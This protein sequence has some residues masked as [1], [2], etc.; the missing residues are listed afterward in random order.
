MPAEDLPA[1]GPE[2]LLH[3]VPPL[4]DPV[5]RPG[6][7]RNSL[8]QHQSRQLLLGRRHVEQL[9]REALEPASTGERVT[10]RGDPERDWQVV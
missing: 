7:E 5:I 4:H 1:V 6:L 2:D 8:N 9:E 3:A 10:V